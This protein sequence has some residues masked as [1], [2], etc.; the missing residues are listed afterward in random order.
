M[1]TPIHVRS[2]NRVR[3][4]SFDATVF[5]TVA[6]LLV[7]IGATGAGPVDGVVLPEGPFGLWQAAPGARGVFA[8]VT[9]AGISALVL[10]AI[11]LFRLARDGKAGVRQVI[12]AAGA[13]SAPTL[14]AQPLLSLDAF[15]YAAQG[16][17]VAVGL[18]PYSGGPVL[19]GPG[20]VL[21]AV[22]PMW[23]DTP[24]PYGPLALAG[25]RGLSEISGENLVLF[26]LLLRL[27]AV[28]AV[29]AAGWLAAQLAAPSHRPVALALVLANPVTVLHLVGGAHLD[30]VLAALAALTVVAVRK[31]W[32]LGAAAVAALALAIK[33]PGLVL[34]GYVGLARFRSDE[35]ILR[36]FGGISA[37]VAVTLVT[38]GATAALVP[39]GWGWVS[40]MGVP[41]QVR[42]QY[43]PP[44][45]IAD[46][47]YLVT[48]FADIP[49]SYSTMLDVTRIG[50]A[51]LGA[52]LILR[53][54]DH[55]AT[56]PSRLRAA[57]RIGA[58]LLVVTLAAPVV[59]AWYIAWGLAL[60]GAGSRDRT[61]KGILALCAALSFTAMPPQITSH[62]L[63]IVGVFVMLG[64][65]VVIAL[66]PRWPERTA[67]V[68][69][70]FRRAGVRLS[71][72]GAGNGR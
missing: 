58:A 19:L 49:V 11:W 47:G 42:H 71:E 55:A 56:E 6:A 62:S 8:L 43:A 68:A 60:L 23:R 65:T 4:P 61:R 16:R 9:L 12:V 51:I 64:V 30:A 54:L 22:S 38:L 69:A 70:A 13:W 26:T 44:T 21:D 34:L 32:W 40:A 33:L 27:L 29:V 35:P 59:H 53:L 45:L 52:L 15:S 25:L 67:V 1:A 24:A 50:C 31:Q 36:R 20:P 10:A 72:L 41:G 14:L 48:L 28:G 2:V 7:V 37:M 57:G 17:M 63:A 39:D 46:L 3:A 5:G 18:N 66:E